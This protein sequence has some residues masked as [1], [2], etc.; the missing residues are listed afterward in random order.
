MFADNSEVSPVYRT[1]ASALMERIDNND[2]PVGSRFPSERNLASEYG[3]SRM[4]AR[5]AVSLLA[6]RGYV[7][8]RNGSGTF[9][10]SPKIE[11]DLSVVAGFS[12]RVLQHGI[13]PGA[14]VIEA[15]TVRTSSLDTDVG[16]TLEIPGTELVHVLIRKRTGDNEVLALE[17]SYFPARLCPD[18]LRDELTGSIYALL[19][20]KCGLEPAHLRQKLEVTQ[21]SASAAEV[22]ETQPDAPALQV[23]RVTCDTEGKPVEFARDL[24]RADR[25]QFVSEA[26]A[27]GYTGHR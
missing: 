25:L 12:D 20:Q 16:E 7:E 11:L 27:T 15:N 2:L 17:E 10:A 5:A 9:V 6:Q 26:P 1:I 24:Y 14:S 23:T 21:L 4:T 18:L 8:R 22:L 3:I 19:Q 13:V